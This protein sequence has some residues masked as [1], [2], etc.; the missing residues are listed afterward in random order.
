MLVKRKAL[1]SLLISWLAIST[2]T[3]IALTSPTKADPY[4][5]EKYPM[6]QAYVRSNGDID[7]PTLPIERSGNVY[8]LKDNIVNYTIAIQ[9]D[10]IVFDGNGFSLTIPT[11]AKTDESL[12]R[13][14]GDPSITISG[15]NNIIIKNVKFDNCFTGISVENSSNIIILQNIMVNKGLGVYMTSCS[16]CSIIGNEITD[17]GLSIGDSTFLNIAYNKLSSNDHYGA[18]LSVSY[19]NI[20][21][22][23]IVD[24]SE[25]GLW[26]KGP[27]S[28]NSIFENNFINNEIG[29]LFRGDPNTNVNNTVFN[30]YWSNNQEAIVN[31]D[32]SADAASS[33]DPSPLTSPISTSFDP[34]LFPLPSLTPTA[35]PTPTAQSDAEPFPTTLVATASGVLVAIIGVGLLVYFKKRRH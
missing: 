35:S 15:K 33:V 28:N 9:K 18:W 20:S 3:A 2:L 30:N 24:N 32:N 7:P 8:V 22:N 11:D 21:R 23:D 29:L 12:M 27:N 14:T 10:N 17:T 4:I 6:E 34:S 16:N 25:K 19:S 1:T 13:R 31:M 26:F 5:P